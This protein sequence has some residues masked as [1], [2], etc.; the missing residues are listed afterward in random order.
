MAYRLRAR[1]RFRPVVSDNGEVGIAGPWARRGGQ[2]PSAVGTRR[3]TC[4]HEDEERTTA[5]ARTRGEDTRLK[6][7]TDDDSLLYRVYERRLVRELAGLDLPRHLAVIVDGN[8]RWAKAAGITTA[9]GHRRGGAK[10]TE[11]LGWCDELGIPLVTVWMLSNDNLRRPAEEL[12]DLFEIIAETVE[13]IS[14]AGYRVRLAGSVDALPEA[15]RER[16]ACVQEKTRAVRTLEVNVAIGY[17][18]REE[19]VEAVRELV[20]DLV[21]TGTDPEQIADAITVEHIGQ[22][23]YTRG[24]PDPDLIIRTSGEQRLSGFLMWQSAHS[25]FWFC[26]TNW[27]GFRRVDLLRAL[28]EYCYR[29]R[30]YGV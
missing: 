15:T 24:Q 25:E 20:R 26:E 4:S 19:I 10:V 5:T 22:H 16:I 2:V 18:G 8:R 29:D 23:L 30:R 17:G 9:E 11:F 21:A 12:Q 6:D 27:P 7:V 14:E 1:A 28:R 13:K 3:A